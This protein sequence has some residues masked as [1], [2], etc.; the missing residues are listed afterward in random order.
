M[1]D[2]SSP[3]LGKLRVRAGEVVYRKGETAETLFLILSGRVRLR[4]SSEAASEVLVPGDFFG[5][6]SLLEGT[7]RT[8]WAEVLEDAELLQLNR[9]TFLRMLRRSPRICVKMMRRLVQRLARLGA[10]LEALER[11]EPR[12]PV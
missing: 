8:H 9:R 5:E 10:R 12:P 2:P 7:P 6:A 3:A 11:Q 1:V 4:A